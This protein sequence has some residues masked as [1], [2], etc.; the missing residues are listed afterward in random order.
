M[1]KP[2]VVVFV[3]LCIVFV[4]CR[5]KDL[6]TPV[7]PSLRPKG[8]LNIKLSNYVGTRVLIPDSVLY[9]AADSTKFAV[10]NYNY[11]ISNLVFTDHE[12]NKFAE[13]ESY[14]LALSSDPSSLSFTVKGMPIAHYTSVSFMI[15]VD[16]VRN[17][18]GA[19]TGALD[20]KY[21]MFWSW[22][23]GYIM[24]K[25]EGEFIPASGLPQDFS[26]HIAGYRAPYSV[27]QS[28]QLKFNDEA[29]VTEHKIPTISIKSDLNV[30]FKSPGFS[31]FAAMPSIGSEGAQAL[32]ISQNYKD[33]FSVTSVDNP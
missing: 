22:S 2:C 19:Q 3:L 1:A 13:E 20:P 12:G 16:S 18:S 9:T 23:T 10:S 4:S 6:P 30:W 27:L 24:A 31:G 25:A 28:V 33:M 17:M 26:Y 15:G 8:S 5:K 21:G 14:H 7:D 32:K 29:V 11:Y